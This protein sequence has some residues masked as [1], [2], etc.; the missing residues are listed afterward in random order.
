MEVSMRTRLSFVAAALVALTLPATAQD[1]PDRLDIAGAPDFAQ[2][3]EAR[4]PPAAKGAGTAPS[5]RPADGGDE[6]PPLV[7]NGWDFS[8]PETIPG[9]GPWQ[10]PQ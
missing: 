7:E 8:R 6:P 2:P 1:R 9:F 10:I 4:T 3:P 5:R